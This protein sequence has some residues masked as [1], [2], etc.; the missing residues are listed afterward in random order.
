MRYVTEGMIDMFRIQASSSGFALRGHRLM[1]RSRTATSAVR[2]AMLEC[3]AE[4]YQ[5]RDR[6]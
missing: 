1:S 4:A 5:P 3:M 6:G 2:R